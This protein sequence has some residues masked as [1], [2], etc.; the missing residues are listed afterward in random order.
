MRQVDKVELFKKHLRS[1]D[2]LHAKYSVQTKSTVVGDHEWGH[3]QIDAISLFL[4]TLA[5]MTA[6]GLQ[7]VRNFDEVAFVQNLVYYIEVGYRIP[8]YGIWERG[9]KTNQGICELNASS[10]GMAKAA[11][12]A[13][14]DVGDLFSDGSKGS[15]I[16]VLPDEVQQC[17]AV[18][19]SMLPRESFSKEIDAALLSII[20]YPAF[21]VE[22]PDLVQLT[23]ATIVDTLLG[24]YGCR[25]FL[26]DGYK[27]ALEDPNRLYYMNSELQ[28]FEDIECEWPVFVC[29][30]M[31]DAMF[32]GD[33][34]ASNAFWEQLQSVSTIL[35]I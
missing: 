21:A 15:I 24:R 19:A 16:H 7:I 30:L 27:T 23:R 1:I 10:I 13:M 18:L 4:L 5:Q 26:R 25:R 32:I 12:Q 17:A 6:S 22:D 28:K 2:G 29:Y 35:H 14:N 33:E 8:D 3:L 11:L 20:A 31:L 9:D 34:E